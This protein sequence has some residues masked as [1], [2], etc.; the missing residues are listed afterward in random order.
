MT[1]RVLVAAGTTLQEWLRRLSI[2][3]P[4]TVVARAHTGG[5]VP[6]LAVSLMPRTHAL[7][8]PALGFVLPAR[9]NALASVLSMAI[10]MTAHRST[11]TVR[12]AYF[13][14]ETHVAIAQ[15]FSAA[16][17]AVFH[18]TGP[19]PRALSDARCTLF[20]TWVVHIIAGLVVPCLV[21][22]W[23]LCGARARFR[24]LAGPP[25]PLPDPCIQSVLHDTATLDNATLCVAVVAGS[26]LAV[27]SVLEWVDAVLP[28]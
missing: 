17:R 2:L 16:T 15:V 13:G 5:A 22:R 9:A 12:E 10:V 28:A 21:T 14:R 25:L 7:A 26:S 19:P 1:A 18:P 24:K 3:P 6:L 20:V 8:L 11:V 27:W 23:W 4:A